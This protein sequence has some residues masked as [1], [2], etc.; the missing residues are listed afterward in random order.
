VQSKS[1]RMTEPLRSARRSIDG[2]TRAVRGMLSDQ[3]RSV[4]LR[5]PMSVTTKQKFKSAV[6]QALPVLFKHTLAYR[7]WANGQRGGRYGASPSVLTS[8]RLNVMEPVTY[9]PLLQAKPL[10]QRPAKLICFYLPQYHAIAEND[11]WWGAGFT[12]WTNVVPAEPHFEGHYQPH[13][14]GELGNYNLL[15]PAVQR[16]QVELAKLYGIEGF[17]FYFYWFAGH[18][19]LE[20]PIRNYLDDS[21][22]D[23][24]FCLCWA[25]ENWSRRWDGLDSEILI[26]Q[27]HSPADDL[28]FIA[29]VG[30][31]MRD[32][33]Y[34]RIDGKPLLLLYRPSLLPSAKETARRWRDWCND[35][36]IGEIYLAY[37]QSFEVEDPAKYGF[38]AAIEFPPNNSSPPNITDTVLPL[39]ED[40]A[41]TVYDWRVFVERSEKYEQPGYKLY[42]S[43]CPAWDNTARRKNRGTVFQHSSPTLYQRWLENAINYTVQQTAN[44]DQ[45]LVFVNA[46]N[47]WAEGAHLEPDQRYGYAWLQATKNALVACGGDI[48]QRRI[49][50]VSHDAHPHGAQYLALNL[51]RVLST[52]FGFQVDLVLLGKGLLTSEYEKWATV[53]DLSGTDPRGKIAR[54]LA[55]RLFD[56]GHEAAIVNT[57]VSGLFLETLQEAGIRCVALVHELKGVINDNNLQ[58]HAEKIAQHAHAVVFAAEHVEASFQ[59]IAKTPAF[60]VKIRHQGLYKKNSFRRIC[61]E[62]RDKLRRSLNLHHNAKIVLA[63]GYADHRKGV[64]LFVDIGLQILKTYPETYFVWVGH[65]DATTA[66][67]I[68]RKI[69]VGKARNH[70]LFVGRKNDTDMYFAGSDIYAMTSREDPFPSVVMEAMEVGLPIVGFRGAGGFEA[71]LDQ[72]CGALV[73]KGDIGEF[74]SSV[75]ALLGKPGDSSVL[76]S[77]GR[78]IIQQS[79][80]FRHYIYDLLEF[81]GMPLKKISAIVPNYNYAQ[82]LP[83]RLNSILKQSYPIFELIVIDDASVDDSIEV[84]QAHMSDTPL[85]FKLITN[86]QNSG[87][88]FKQWKNG[89]KHCTGEIIWICEADDDAAADFVDSL[90]GLFDD[91]EVAIAYTQ[92][93]QIDEQGRMIAANYFDYTDEISSEKWKND[94]VST[95]HD[96]LLN[97]FGVK[98]TIP[99]VS[100]VLFNSV[101]LQDA[102]SRSDDYLARLKIAGDWYIYSNILQHGKIGYVS[103]AL[104]FHRR[105]L[106]SVTASSSSKA[107]HLAEIIFMQE[108]IEQIVSPSVELKEKAIKYTQK[109]YSQFALEEK[110][111]KNPRANK[112]V[113]AVLNSLSSLA[114]RE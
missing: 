33:R 99:N 38:D 110:Y 25:N 16:R 20:T 89:I 28:A 90:V 5:L 100:A 15:D 68:D 78:S 93:Q 8:H 39:R 35:N 45:R 51:S 94:Y 81:A 3:A 41:A 80:S 83:Q 79:F 13:V 57:T 12:E 58:E 47:E 66:A 105:H 62:A 27:R 48:A 44:P 108:H 67:E 82:Y 49:V 77:V 17:C 114:N 92:S 23:L 24:P 30:E 42:R 19:L 111:L 86:E 56:S 101:A 95:G 91:P 87:S 26:A 53:H 59:S 65:Q 10:R 50:L 43:V 103:R 36:G 55:H 71:L 63:V 109:I 11:A 76:G 88:V 84:I 52:D 32:P 31:Y 22:L 113:D 9:V 98:N 61:I 29:H 72:G 7:N 21:A 4:W 104:N 64:D 37:T 2:A 54:A 96:E 73:A 85:D 14:S 40:F 97:A 70:F 107:S 69:Q 75:S 60:K 18:R 102:M 74:A 106:K 46:W 112:Q 1:W 6:F 34:I